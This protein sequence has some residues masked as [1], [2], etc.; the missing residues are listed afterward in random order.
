M[1]DTD[2]DPKMPECL[3][4]Q[5]IGLLGKPRTENVD[6][7]IRLVQDLDD[8]PRIQYWSQ[9]YWGYEFD[10]SGIYLDFDNELG[11]FNHMILRIL[12]PG[13]RAGMRPYAGNLPF[14]ITIDDSAE[15]VE[16]KFRG[17]TM[18]VKDYR[19]DMDL[20]P[21]VVTFHFGTADLE[22]PGVGERK[23]TMV[24]MVYEESLR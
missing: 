12:T 13:V 4:E 24:S 23:L 2:A 17:G 7:L 5:L 18:A 22:A 9:K 21:L 6:L 14:G 3:Y 20:R 16:Q 11:I 10:K 1:R 15:Q 19:F 8:K